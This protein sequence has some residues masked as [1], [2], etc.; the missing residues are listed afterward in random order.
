[1]ACSRLALPKMLSAPVR[2]LAR[3]RFLICVLFHKA[4][5]QLSSQPFATLLPKATRRPAFLVAA[6]CLSWLLLFYIFLRR[7]CCPAAKICNHFL[8]TDVG[9][10]NAYVC[11]LPGRKSPAEKLEISFLHRLHNESDCMIRGGKYCNCKGN[12][13]FIQKFSPKK[14]NLASLHKRDR[15][16]VSGEKK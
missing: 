8:P 11:G 2:G 6:L 5:F 15:T 9:R 14:Q 7:W 13:V 4:R 3:P 12:Q 1:M 16:F 10:G